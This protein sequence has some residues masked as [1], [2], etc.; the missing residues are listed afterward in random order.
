MLTWL[1]DF[2]QWV[3]PTPEYILTPY[4]EKRMVELGREEELNNLKNEIARLKKETSV[5]YGNAFN[6]TGQIV[7]LVM[8]VVLI[9]IF[10][11]ILK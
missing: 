11:K 10:Y 9:F 6:S 7:T 3:Y 4:F 5:A 8:S 2:K 1:H